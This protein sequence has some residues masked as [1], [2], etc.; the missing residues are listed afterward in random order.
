VLFELDGLGPAGEA[1]LPLP[2]LAAGDFELRYLRKDR[3][4]DTHAVAAH[5]AVALRDS[6]DPSCAARAFTLAVDAPPGRP[7]AFCAGVDVRIAWSA[8]EDV[9]EATLEAA[10][11]GVIE[12]AAPAAGC[13]APCAASHESCAACFA[14]LC[15]AQAGTGAPCAR[16]GDVLLDGAGAL[17]PPAPTQPGTYR[18][19]LFASAAHFISSDP[20][21]CSG[22]F[23]VQAGARDVCGVCGG[24]NSSCKGCDGKPNS[25]K[26]IDECGVCGGDGSSCAGCDGKPNSGK[27][28]DECGVCG[29]DGSSC[30]GCD[31]RPNSGVEFDSCGVCGGD[32]GHCSD[33][34]VVQVSGTLEGGA[35]DGGSLTVSWRAPSN[36]PALLIRVSRPLQTRPATHPASRPPPLSPRTNWTRL[37]LPPVLSGHVSS[38][39]R[40]NRRA[41]AASAQD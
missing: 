3:A 34:Y 11:V 33:P 23:E 10:V 25:G 37:V 1:Q 20:Q 28:L 12:D 29:G 24:D 4:R 22:A 39:P 35:C 38:I 30:A 21:M 19:C 18:A 14:R 15:P 9:E 2:G 40:G 27:V 31:G 7:A 36:H 8:P 41:A 6:Q 13:V 32:D 17:W 5:A 26:V 16:E